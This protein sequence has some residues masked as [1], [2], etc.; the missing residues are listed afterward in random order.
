MC[1]LLNNV[2]TSIKK[3]FKSLNTFLIAL[4]NMRDFAFTITKICDLIFISFLLFFSALFISVTLNHLCIKLFPSVQGNKKVTT[5]F[6]LEI[7]FRI[8][9]IIVMCYIFRNLIQ[10]IPSPFDNKHGFFHDKVKEI[11]SGTLLTTL[12]FF[13]QNN[14]RN[15]AT[16]LGNNL[17][18]NSGFLKSTHF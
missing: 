18:Q 8:T 7:V 9:F 12:A 5:S 15:N 4:N 11:S 13:F 16:F 1:N 3:I 2:F 14:L 6:I 10:E 17:L